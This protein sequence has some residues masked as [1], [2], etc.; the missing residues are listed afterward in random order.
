MDWNSKSRRDYLEA[1]LRLSPEDRSKDRGASWGS[2]Q[3]IFLHIIEDYIW[4]FEYVPQGKGEDQ[5][6]ALV[7]REFDEEELRSLSRRV[8]SS[9]RQ[10][11]DSLT[12]GALGRPFVVRG[13]SGDGKP[14]TMTT[15]PAD[16][17]WHMVEEQLQH[18]GELNAL[19][20]QLDINPPTHAW[21]S[22]E[23]AWTH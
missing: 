4:W 10:F 20:W 6:V 18:I 22:S 3:E 13:A 9:V 7:G 14:Y 5:F 17:V 15:C 1:I 8:D 12:S 19:F 21:F 23:L 2:I 11:M 16:I